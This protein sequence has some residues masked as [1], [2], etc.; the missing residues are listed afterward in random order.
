MESGVR[1]LR[2]PLYVP[3]QPS[4]IKRLLHLLSFSISSCLALLKLWR[5]KPDLVIYVVPTLFC[6]LQI[7]LYSR[8]SGARV[9]IHVQDFEVDALF[10]LG[11][12]QGGG[13][14]L[15]RF[16]YGLERWLM[17]RFDHVSTISAGML[18]KAHAKGVDADRLILFPNWSEVQ[19]FREAE[20]DPSLLIGLGVDPTHRVVLYSGNMGEKQGLELVL[21]AAQ[22]LSDQELLTFLLVG[23]G[24]GKSRLQARA[25]EL[26]VKN[27]IFAPLLPYDDLPRLLASADCHLVVQR[28]GVADAVLPSKLT[29]IL[30]VGGNAVITADEDTTLGKLC[31]DFSG[32]AACVEP[33]SLPALISGIQMALSMPSPNEI[34]VKYAQDNLDKQTIL[35]RFMSGLIC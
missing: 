10:G 4:T 31:R 11:M 2:C 20:R 33:E 35:T 19:R 6:A 27:V 23:E 32:I 25:A 13:G 16:A 17:R 22:V 15:A 24:G 18:A 1:V 30:A 14:V 28:R 29:N 26:G 7:L 3:A 21:E 9:V 8:L 34:A 5:L 12:T